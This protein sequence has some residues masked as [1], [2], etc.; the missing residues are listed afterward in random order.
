M[1]KFLYLLKNVFV[2]RV[3]QKAMTPGAL[4]FLLQLFLQAFISVIAFSLCYSNKLL[5]PVRFYSRRRNN[6]FCPLYRL[7]DTVARHSRSDSRAD[8]CT[9]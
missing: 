1:N 2:R 7:A 4:L 5:L 3:K 8:I 9:P 6:I